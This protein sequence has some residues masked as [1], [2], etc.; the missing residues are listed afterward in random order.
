M[1]QK[2]TEVL[3]QISE[4]EHPD[5]ED[6]SVLESLVEQARNMDDPFSSV[7]EFLRL[8]ERHP[9][10][11]LGMPGPVVHFVET[12]FGRGYEPLLLQSTRRCATPL[13]VWMLH[14]VSNGC[15]TESEAQV[16]LKEL[17]R[18]GAEV[19]GDAGAEARLFLAD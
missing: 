2:D 11:D 13:T 7:A 19:P 8:L 5:S 10:E 18:I 15:S 3:Q 17:E 14:R 9:A 12:F 6:L 4:Y 16:Y 1:N